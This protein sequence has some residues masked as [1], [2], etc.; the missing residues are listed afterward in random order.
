MT[1]NISPASTENARPMSAF[2]NPAMFDNR[3]AESNVSPAAEEKKQAASNVS[4]AE[5][6]VS[7]AA[8]RECPDIPFMPKNP[9]YGF[10]YVPY[11]KLDKTFAPEEAM[12]HGTAFPE[13]HHPYPAGTKPYM[14][15]P[16][17]YYGGE[18]RG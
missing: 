6:K 15:G 14:C 12:S 17:G 5:T 11:Q 7:P 1:G 16:T 10:A 18:R 2:I 13:L 3:R 9:R 4:P 8:D